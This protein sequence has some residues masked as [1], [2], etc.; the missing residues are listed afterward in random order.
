MAIIHEYPCWLVKS[1]KV[2]FPQS[3]QLWPLSPTPVPPS[4]KLTSVLCHCHWIQLCSVWF[5]CIRLGESL[6]HMNK[7]P[8]FLAY[9]S[10]GL[11]PQSD[12]ASLLDF[13]S[14][15]HCFMR[16]LVPLAAAMSHLPPV[17]PSSGQTKA[18]FF[19]LTMGHTTGYN[20]GPRFLSWLLS[21][22]HKVLPW[23][24]GDSTQSCL[25]FL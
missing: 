15:F 10:F 13:S 1:F 3:H 9:G 18:S 4:A 21:F 20:T 8:L 14:I 17:P 11:S 24:E 19:K 2:H 7:D 16:A 25:K 6:V 22:I 5:L 12:A 23:A